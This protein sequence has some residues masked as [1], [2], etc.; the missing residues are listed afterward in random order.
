M[1]TS[2]THRMCFVLITGWMSI[3]LFLAG[4]ISVSV[5]MLQQTWLLTGAVGM[6]ACIGW[7]NLLAQETKFNSN[8]IRE[9]EIQSLT[10]PLTNL[11]NRRGFDIHLNDLIS[12]E[13]KNKRRSTERV[14][15]LALLDV[16]HFKTVND[17]NGHPIGDRMLEYVAQTI[18][19]CMPERSLA[20]RLGG[21]EFA[22]VYVDSPP[23][24]VV[25][26]LKAIKSTIDQESFD[27]PDL[28]H[29]TVSVGLTNYHPLDDFDRL[30]DR[31][32][33]ALYKT[34]DAGRNRITFS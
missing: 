19:S 4:S 14:I 2:M 25:W 29:T 28:V 17:S 24:L 5:P 10:D 11:S 30:F 8:V 20:S 23:E 15:F 7:G 13:K 26:S 21:D 22:I 33:R 9:Y 1:R 16:D 31:A 12:C 27:R 6:I 32:D 3:C 18:Y 34:K